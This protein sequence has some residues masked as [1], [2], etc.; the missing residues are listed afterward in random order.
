MTHGVHLKGCR[1]A[2]EQPCSCEFNSYAYILLITLVIAAVQL[3]GSVLSGSLALFADTLHVLLDGA[4]AGISMFVAHRVRTHQDPGGLRL[5]WMRVS[6]L[7]LIAA[8]IWVA[9]E[10]AQR[11]QHPQ[12]VVGWQVMV[13]AFIGGYLN[14]RQHELVPHDHSATS[15]MQRYHVLGDLL[16]SI[17]VVF[18]GALMWLT[19]D[20]RIDPI[21][22]LAIA[23]FIG[24]ITVR[25]LISRHA[26]SSNGHVH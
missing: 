15:W 9:T 16:S 12:P 22:S 17:A 20:A 26:G 13:A 24:A 3:A 21:L 23:L 4:S 14:Y 8:M 7:L 11:Y 19:G 25:M 6:G 2:S 18:G 5:F 10:A 1:A